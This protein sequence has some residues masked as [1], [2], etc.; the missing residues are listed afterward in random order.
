[1]IQT[2]IK[3]I[4]DYFKKR[5]NYCE[6]NSSEEFYEIPVVVKDINGTPTAFPIR[7]IKEN[8]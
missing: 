8:E 2:L 5:S 7:E 3:N 1:M 6:T 4:N